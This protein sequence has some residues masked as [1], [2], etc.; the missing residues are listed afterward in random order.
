MTIQPVG[1]ILTF[2]QR[3]FNL[4]VLVFVGIPLLFFLG[5]IVG[6]VRARHTQEE[7]SRKTVEFEVT[8]ELLI[9]TQLQHELVRLHGRLGLAM[10]EANR[11]NFADAAINATQFFDG[12]RAALSNRRLPEVANRAEL[13][14]ILAV[15]DEISSD[16]ALADAGV[17]QKLSEQY[18]R[19]DRAISI[20]G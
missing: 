6:T 5:F 10:Y 18:V 13:E 11:N 15:R 14:S 4:I 19:F 1:R 3:P 9:R 20:S 16:L 7:L 17:K 12:L 8:Q 2:F